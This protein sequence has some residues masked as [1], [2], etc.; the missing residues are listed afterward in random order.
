MFTV[1]ELGK[2]CA[3]VNVLPTMYTA[4]VGRKQCYVLLRNYSEGPEGRN[5]TMRYHGTLCR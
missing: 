2:H 5:G 4:L 3:S 1:V